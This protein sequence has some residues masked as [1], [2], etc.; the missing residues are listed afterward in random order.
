MSTSTGYQDLHA[1]KALK[2]HLIHVGKSQRSLARK[3]KVSV[4]YLNQVL[5]G[6]KPGVKVRQ[7]LV[8]LGIPAEL[9]APPAAK[10]TPKRVA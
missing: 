3:L 7:G 9:V 6:R 5:M 10:P 2:I 8:E 4:Q 1:H